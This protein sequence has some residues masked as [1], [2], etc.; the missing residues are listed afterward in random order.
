MILPAV[1][2]VRLD[3]YA[4]HF[5]GGIGSQDAQLENSM[6]SSVDSA[7]MERSAVAADVGVTLRKAVVLGLGAYVAGTHEPP[8]SAGGVSCPLTIWPR[9][10]GT[11]Y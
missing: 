1:L 9:T 2:A 7:L 5:S 10:L 3:G 11:S 8:P 4:N 6:G